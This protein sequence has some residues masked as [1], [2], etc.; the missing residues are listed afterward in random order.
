MSG[1]HHG[2]VTCRSG[3]GQPGHAAPPPWPCPRR[4]A[5]ARA[6][7]HRG[8]RGR[9]HE[10]VA[11]V[12]PRPLVELGRA[13]PA[14]S[15]PPPAPRWARGTRSA[16]SAAASRAARRDRGRTARAARARHAVGRGPARASTAVAFRPCARR[17]RRRDPT[18]RGCALTWR[19]TQPGS[20]RV[21]AGD[22]GVRPTPRAVAD[23]ASLLRRRRHPSMTS[24]SMVLTVQPTSSR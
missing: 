6:R 8:R 1:A 11:V 14:G 9:G 18:R 4:N 17:R 2:S 21:D 3:R 24:P 16:R 22:D 5:G 19:S 7:G 10:A 15:R 13:R 20:S 23:G 12:G